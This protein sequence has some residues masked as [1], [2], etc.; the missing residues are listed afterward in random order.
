M[1]KTKA[2]CK[3]KAILINFSEK[4]RVK[5]IEI[6]ETFYFADLF[7][8]NKQNPGFLFKTFFWD[9]VIELK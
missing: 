5:K 9:L 3:K 1:I 7:Q 4:K 8:T 2:L 6:V